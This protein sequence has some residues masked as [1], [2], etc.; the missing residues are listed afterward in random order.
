MSDEILK[1]KLNECRIP[2]DVSKRILDDIFGCRLGTVFQ[3]GLVDSCDNDDYKS[4]L[5]S[6]VQAWQCSEM[7]SSADI[8]SG[9]RATKLMPFMTR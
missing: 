7:S 1:T 6:L 9:F 8:L 2:S 3:E 4:K 5:D